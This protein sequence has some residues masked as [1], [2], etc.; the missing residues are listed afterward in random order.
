LS[1]P[2]DLIRA[3]ACTN[4]SQFRGCASEPPSI[5]RISS[6]D[7]FPFIRTQ[8]KRVGSENIFIFGL[9]AHEV[10][11]RRRSGLDARAAIAASPA[12]C[13]VL[14]TIAAGVFSSDDED[15]YM[16]LL[17]SLINHDYFW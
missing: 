4:F 5:F 12:L 9:T 14:N 17:D 1:E 2:A 15:R 10:T 11:E 6:I 16:R 8:H 13:E 3:A 7:P